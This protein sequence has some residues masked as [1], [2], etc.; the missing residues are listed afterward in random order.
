MVDIVSGFPACPRGDKYTILA[1]VKDAVLQLDGSMK[2]DGVILPSG[3][4]CVER[5]KELNQA[6]KVFACSEHAPQR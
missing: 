1:D 4:F 5:I 6:V 3:Q 2:V